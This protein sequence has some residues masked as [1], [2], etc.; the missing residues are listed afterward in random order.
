MQIELVTTPCSGGGATHGLAAVGAPQLRGGIVDADARLEAIE[1]Q[2]GGQGIVLLPTGR[3][4]LA[5]QDLIQR[6]DTHG[7]LLFG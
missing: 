4:A 3:V 2:L 5:S 6:T 7:N 1:T